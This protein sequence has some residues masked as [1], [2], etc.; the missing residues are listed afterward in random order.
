M[1]FR[2]HNKITIFTHVAIPK[3]TKWEKKRKKLNAQGIYITCVTK[4]LFTFC[5]YFSDKMKQK[6][7]KHRAVKYRGLEGIYALS[8]EFEIPQVVFFNF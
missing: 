8:V 4:Y 5:H 1:E 7:T 3:K 6:C 2:C